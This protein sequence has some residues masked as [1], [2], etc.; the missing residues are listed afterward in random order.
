[1]KVPKESRGCE[2]CA[3]E[4]CPYVYP[5]KG[6]PTLQKVNEMSLKEE[7]KTLVDKSPSTIGEPYVHLK[8]FCV[9]CKRKFFEGDVREDPDKITGKEKPLCPNCAEHGKLREKLFDEERLELKQKLRCW[10]KREAW[11]HL[12]LEVREHFLELLKEKEAKQ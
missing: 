8:L 11:F 1:M 5:L 7:D 2:D 4:V 6:C 3:N 12:P 9:C 10:Y